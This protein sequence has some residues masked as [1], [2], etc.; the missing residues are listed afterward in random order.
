MNWVDQLWSL[1]ASREVQR[2]SKE[3]EDLTDYERHVIH[4]ANKCPD[5]GGGL[6]P[7]PRGGSA[8]N[9]CCAV[10][11]SEFNV[12]VI[13]GAVLGQRIS[14]RGPRDVGEKAWCYGL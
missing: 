13:A 6:L 10:C 12:T 1:L 7:G 3:R 14:D 11:H 2:S 8:Q 5:C 4:Q 9:F